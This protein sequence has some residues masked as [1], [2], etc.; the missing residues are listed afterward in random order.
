MASCRLKR[1]KKAI[2]KEPRDNELK[3]PSEN[4]TWKLRKEKLLK[5]KHWTKK[6]VE[7]SALKI[8]NRKHLSL[9]SGT[10]LEIV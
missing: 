7:S 8:I 9:G 4:G 3:D 1:T 10:S 2:E 6:P 5:R